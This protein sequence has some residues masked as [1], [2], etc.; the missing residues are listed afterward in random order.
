MGGGLMQQSRLGKIG[1]A[2]SQLVNVAFLFDHRDTDANES[3]SGRSYRKGWVSAE[4]FINGLIFWDNDHC[5][6][7]FERDLERARSV[8]RNRK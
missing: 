7:A 6:R 5:R 8:L 1:D 3:I 2:L 4:K